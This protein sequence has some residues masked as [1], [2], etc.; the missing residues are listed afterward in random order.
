[1]DKLQTYLENK[2]NENPHFVRKEVHGFLASDQVT[3]LIIGFSVIFKYPKDFTDEAYKFFSNLYKFS[4]VYGINEYLNFMML[5]TFGT[6]YSLVSNDKKEYLFYEI[7]EKFHRPHEL[8]VFKDDDGNPRV[9]NFFG[10][11]KYELL[12]SVVQ[13]SK[14]TDK[15]FIKQYKELKRKFGSV[16]NKEPEGVKVYVN[17][18]PLN[19]D[20]SK[21]T[22][23]NW[24]K[25]FKTYN[26]QNKNYDGWNQPTEFEHGRRF[27]EIISQNPSNYIDF[28]EKI[29]L[30]TNISNTYIVKALEG[31]KDGKTDSKALLR[32]FCLAIDNRA[33]ERENT[34]YLIWITRYFAKNKL[35]DKRVFE[36]LKYNL[37]LL[38]TT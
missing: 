15:K 7:I 34:L 31:L 18:D 21:F 30:D 24:E 20:Y 36:F 17:R 8:K 25:S 26:F 11:G 9:N 12:T 5:E 32:L 28:I 6:I 10:I 4:E 3:D 27:A 2:Y 22:F 37:V 19:A 38:R 13:K 1:M 33:F 23:D 35:T 29:T 16:E 14:L